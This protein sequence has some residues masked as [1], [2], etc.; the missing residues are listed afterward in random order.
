MNVNFYISLMHQIK[1]AIFTLPFSLTKFT[2]CIKHHHNAVYHLLYLIYIYFH[3]IIQIY[4]HIYVYC[5]VY[6]LLLPVNC[7]VYWM[8][9]LLYKCI[10]G[11]INY[12][13]IWFDLIF[14]WTYLWQRQTFV[15]VPHS[16]GDR[17]LTLFRGFSFLLI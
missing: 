7:S 4:C 9:N 16:L 2:N 10:K 8:F 12:Y 14:W 13:L 3:C 6:V 17:F 1:L 15:D 11:S 5:N